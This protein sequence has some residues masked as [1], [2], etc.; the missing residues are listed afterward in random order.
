MWLFLIAGTVI[1]LIRPAITGNCHSSAASRWF[2]A[3]R[4]IGLAG[5]QFADATCATIRRKLLKIGARVH[6][7][8][9]RLKI[10]MA[11]A[12]PYQHEYRRAH[13]LLGRAGR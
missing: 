7:S 2:E 5:T 8:V 3:L 11:S 9:R 4:R 1:S 10:A 12:C 6:L 13:L